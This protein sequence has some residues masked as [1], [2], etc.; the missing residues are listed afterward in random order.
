LDTIQAAVL[1]VKMKYLDRWTKARQENAKVYERL[2]KDSGLTKNDEV[3]LPAIVYRESGVSHYHIYNQFIIRTMQRDA[4]RSY[5]KEQGIGCEVYYP[6]PF[7]LQECF[8]YLEYRKGE[9]PEA[10]EAAQETLGL[11]IYPELNLEQQQCVVETIKS[12]FQ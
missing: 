10:E 2:F 11:P 6:V 9:F 3:K 4:L 5:L 12:F 7:H 1:N 8:S